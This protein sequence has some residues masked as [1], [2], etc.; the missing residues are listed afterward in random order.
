[1]HHFL[2][3]LTGAV[4]LLGCMG[5]SAEVIVDDFTV[6][7][8]S[9]TAN[10]GNG[11]ANSLL[12]GLDTAHVL[13]GERQ[14]TVQGTMSVGNT[15]ATVSTSGSGSL[16]YTSNNPA[17]T[18]AS[19][20]TLILTHA[21]GNRFDTV[22]L[23]GVADQHYFIDVA[24]ANLGVID[25]G[26][27]SQVKL[28]TPFGNYSQ[29]IDFLSSPTP[30]SASVA[31]SGFTGADLTQVYNLSLDITRL[32]TTATFQIDK[33]YSSDLSSVPE[34]RAIAMCVIA[35]LLVA[36]RRGLSGNEQ[37]LVGR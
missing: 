21:P 3:L 18:T 22:D 19:L 34:P 2:R 27:T 33:V 32:S 5:A 17:F 23:S 7:P 26:F 4:T 16:V 9:V 20:G 15:N 37:G 14:I 35:M 24:S 25:P 36:V 10:S 6:G 29:D 31:M 30:Y 13:N 11:N 12:N 28:S 1:M 8:Q